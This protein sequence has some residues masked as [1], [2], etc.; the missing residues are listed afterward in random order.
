MKTKHQG[1]LL[2]EEEAL[3]LHGPRALTGMLHNHCS[4][5]VFNSPLA[6]CLPTPGEAWNGSAPGRE[7]LSPT[8]PPSFLNYLCT[9]LHRGFTYILCH[10]LQNSNV[11]KM[12]LFTLQNRCWTPPHFSA[13]AALPC[14]LRLTCGHSVNRNSAKKE[15][16]DERSR[17]EESE[18]G[19]YI[20][21]LLPTRLL[22]PSFQG[23]DSCWMG[24]S[25]GYS[26]PSGQS[27]NSSP[28]LLA[29]G[30]TI[31]P[32]IHSFSIYSTF[33]KYPVLGCHKNVRPRQLPIKNT[34]VCS[35]WSSLEGRLMETRGR[36][37]SK[38]PLGPPLF[39]SPG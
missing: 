38:P 13:P 27:G 34:S 24:P 19:I 28:L 7:G 2:E 37:A 4:A 1:E 26:C 14:G 18:V 39:V 6:R 16:A 36:L 30:C 11:S 20:T 12:L 10:C 22:C 33:L 29:L 17:Q 3:E 21:R 8:L 35:T 25:Y 31:S 9:G 15:P 5:S 32:L 23:Q